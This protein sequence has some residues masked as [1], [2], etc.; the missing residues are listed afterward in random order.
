M[1]PFNCSADP[2][3]EMAKW[4]E[5]QQQWAQGFV[6]FSSKVGRYVTSLKARLAGT[7]Y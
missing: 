5:A 1:N 4:A 2:E 6:E 7:V 3:V